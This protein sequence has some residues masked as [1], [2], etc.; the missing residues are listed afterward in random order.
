FLVHIK[1][2]LVDANIF[3]GD[4]SKKGN[5]YG[6]DIVQTEKSYYDEVI[7]VP[8][9]EHDGCKCGKSCTCTTCTCGH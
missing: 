9:A 1:W 6:M 5:T 2:G 8:G 3:F 7:E 4:C